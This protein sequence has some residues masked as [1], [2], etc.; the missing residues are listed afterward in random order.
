MIGADRIVVSFATVTELRYLTLRA[1]W[2]ELRTATA[3]SATS[4]SSS[5]HNQTIS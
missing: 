1:D 5:P 2:G 3:W 4:L